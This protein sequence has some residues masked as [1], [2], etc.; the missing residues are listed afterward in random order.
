MII[1]VIIYIY[2]YIH[3]LN[4]KPIQEFEHSHIAMKSNHDENHGPSSDIYFDSLPIETSV[5]CPFGY[6]D[7]ASI[8]AKRCPKSCMVRNVSYVFCRLEHLFFGMFKWIHCMIVCLI[9][10]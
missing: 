6:E 4:P 9:I 10:M 5:D 8:Q 1:M 3:T 7:V 2:I